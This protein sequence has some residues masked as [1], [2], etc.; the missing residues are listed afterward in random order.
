MA[1]AL[2]ASDIY[3]A[4]RRYLEESGLAR[5]LKAFDKETVVA[6][7]AEAVG[8][9]KKARKA[10]AKIQLTHACQL[11]LEASAVASTDG[12]TASDIY[13]AVR[14]YLEESGLAKS[15]KAFDKETAVDENAQ[16]VALPKKAKKAIAKAQ[17]T[18]ACQL[19]LEASAGAAT[20]GEAAAA[21]EAPKK[22]R[23]HSEEV[24]EAAPVAEELHIGKKAKKEQKQEKTS[25]IPFSRVDQDKWRATVKD[26]R[27]LDNTKAATGGDSWGDAASADMLK[28]KGKG[29]RKEMAKKKRASWRGGGEIDQ[30][31]NSIKFDVSSDEGDDEV[32][33][34]P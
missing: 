30:G 4:V 12:L 23:K 3:P 22:K 34:K 16:A 10:I 18:H 15:L 1:A 7:G 13:P 29:F 26:T 5:C 19:V 31:T 6:E 21:E 9:P 11:V 27:M 14:R 8:L 25:G 2:T 32:F 17:L 33:S 28:V 20:N 24:P